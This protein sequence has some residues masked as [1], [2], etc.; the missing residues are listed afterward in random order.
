MRFSIKSFALGFGCAALSLGA[1]TYANAA[2][3]GTLKACANKTTGVMR[4][5][6]KG[7][8]KKTESLLSWNQLGPQG[9]PGAAGT[10]GVAGAK[11]DAGAAGAKGE[12][13]AAGASAASTLKQRVLLGLSV[14][15]YW[16][17]AGSRCASNTSTLAILTSDSGRKYAI[18][19]LTLNDVVGS[20]TNGY[21]ESLKA[22]VP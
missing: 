13:G 16:L 10:D 7:S 15:R 14:G 1:I 17:E 2:S 11:G 19:S 8:C 5:I 18:C 12:T 6:S 4:Y 20:S 3:N 21:I 22:W 9:L